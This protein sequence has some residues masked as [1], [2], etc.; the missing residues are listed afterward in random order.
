M[1]HLKYYPSKDFKIQ[2]SDY[3]ILKF[4]AHILKRITAHLH[5]KKTPPY[6]IN[7]DPAVH[8]VPYPANIGIKSIRMDCPSD[9]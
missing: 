5:A 1:H 7:L 2:W 9:F 3:V 8:E 6:V 4:D